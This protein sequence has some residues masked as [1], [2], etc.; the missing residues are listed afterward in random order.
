MRLVQIDD[1]TDMLTKNFI[2]I[3]KQDRSSKKSLNNEYFIV[4][5]RSCGWPVQ[6]EAWPACN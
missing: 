4:I 5:N 1:T 2:N 6:G 3:N